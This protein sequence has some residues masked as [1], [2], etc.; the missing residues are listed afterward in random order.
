MKNRCHDPQNNVH[1]YLAFGIIQV[2]YSFEKEAQM[3]SV[4]YD[5][6]TKEFG[7]VVAVNDL[8]L[9]IDDKEFIVLVG[10]SGCGKTTALR[11][12]AGLE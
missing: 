9:A 6:I 7:E 2:L 12:L 11:M 5:H 8:S 3:A 4:M 1:T 10:P